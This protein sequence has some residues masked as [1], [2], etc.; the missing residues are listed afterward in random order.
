MKPRL[1]TSQKWTPFPAEFSEKIIQVMSEN[2]AEQAAR[3]VFTVEGRIYPQEIL[4]RV[5]YNEGGRLK[6]DNFEASMEYSMENKEQAAQ[7]RIFACLDAI[8]SSFDELFHTRAEGEEM[9]LP[10]QWEAFDFEGEIVWM[11]YSTINTR[12]EDEADRLLNSLNDDTLVQEDFETD[13]A[14]ARAIVD[15][16]LADQ[17]QQEIRKGPK[18]Q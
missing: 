8:G 10:A 16:E 9:E 18:L 5:G 14:M 2:F 11:Q 7:S 1:H 15:S 6:Q 3:G 12:L 4:M 17:I 13:D